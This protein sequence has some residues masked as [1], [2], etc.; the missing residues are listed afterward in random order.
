MPSL[1][2]WCTTNELIHLPLSYSLYNKNDGVCLSIWGLSTYLFSPLTHLFGYESDQCWESITYQRQYHCSMSSLVSRSN[3]HQID[4]TVPK[5]FK[6]FSF[7]YC[8]SGLN[9]WTHNCF[10]KD[11]MS[12]QPYPWSWV[13][14]TSCKTPMLY[15]LVFC[16]CRK[17]RVT[18]TAK[19][20]QQAKLASLRWLGS[21]L[22]THS[23][24]GMHSK[25]MLSRP[26]M[27]SLDSMFH[28]IQSHHLSW[29]CFEQGQLI[30]CHWTGWYLTIVVLLN[31]WCH[32][33]VIVNFIH[34]MKFLT[35]KLN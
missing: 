12:S 21:I 14:I 23:I 26:I 10:C 15:G 30:T 32:L 5:I 9:I 34:K 4:R 35:F 2:T 33:N 16:W 28:V 8:R 25:F 3:L 13:S 11:A 20:L 22:L 24:L 31:S 1:P 27:G 17:R 6:D 29:L 7:H 19:L 18:T